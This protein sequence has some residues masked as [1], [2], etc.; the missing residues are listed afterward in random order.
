MK[1]II[2][3]LAFFLTACASSKGY[4]D[5]KDVKMTRDAP[6]AWCKPV[7]KVTGR[8]IT[9]KQTREDAVKDL[10]RHAANKG[11]TYVRVAQVSDHGTSI[12]GTA[13]I[14]DTKED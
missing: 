11:A 5:P 4:I 13:F 2:L 7:G 14:C 3:I 8:V 9:T 10:Q 1:Y 6:P 12:T